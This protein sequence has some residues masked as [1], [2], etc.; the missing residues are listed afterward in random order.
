VHVSR[1][2]AGLVSAEDID[3][4]ERSAAAGYECSECGQPGELGGEPATLVVRRSWP[5]VAH[6]RIAHGR[7]SPS[8]VIDTGQ[9][10]QVAPELTM[11]VLAAVLPHAAGYRAVVIAEPPV[12]ISAASAAGDR[13]DLVVAALMQRGLSMVASAG[14]RPPAAPGWAVSLPS[15]AEAVITGLGGELFYAGEMVQPT[16]WR[17]LAAGLGAVELLVGTVGLA[18]VGP[19]DVSAGLRAL[20]AVARAGRLVGGTIAVR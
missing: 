13:V 8:R 15:A 3:I 4:L 14:Q 7:C 16:P 17:R 6:A 10:Y 11:T 19:G 1:E 2:V 9:A 20:G 5:Q 12:S 18:A